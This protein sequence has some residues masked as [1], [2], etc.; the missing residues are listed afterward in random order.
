MITIDFIRSLV[1]WQIVIL[2]LSI[3]EIV[4][5]LFPQVESFR[6]VFLATLPVAVSYG[7]YFGIR[8]GEDL[9]MLIT[10]F[11]FAYFLYPLIVK[12]LKRLIVNNLK[13]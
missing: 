1:D 10:S 11:S 7:W 6:A 2:V 5:R 13:Q 8:N 9:R 4:K 3:G 12:P